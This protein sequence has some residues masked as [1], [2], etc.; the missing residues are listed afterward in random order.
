MKEYVWNCVSLEE[1]K[2]L[3]SRCR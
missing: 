1:K 2:T 3:I